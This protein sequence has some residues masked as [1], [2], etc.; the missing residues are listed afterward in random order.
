[1]NAM[2]KDYL[3][4]IGGLGS[5]VEQGALLLAAVFLLG[6][7]ALI[8]ATWMMRREKTS[9]REGRSVGLRD[10]D[11]YYFIVYEYR[12]DDGQLL[13]A[14]SE[15]S[16]RSLA[17][18][19]PGLMAQIHVPE[20]RPDIAAASPR[21]VAPAAGVLLA[22]SGLFAGF[23]ALT[24][25]PVNG[26]T[27]ATGIVLVVFFFKKFGRRMPT[28]AMREAFVEW[29]ERNRNALVSLP[30][31]LP[32]SLTETTPADAQDA[33]V[34]PA[35]EKALRVI[36]PLY[37]LAGAAAIAGALYFSGGMIDL[38]IA[39]TSTRGIVTEIVKDQG[40][41]VHVVHFRDKD[42]NAVRFENKSRFDLPS[43]EEGDEV[44]VLYME[45]DPAGTAA[46]DHGW[47]AWLAPGLLACFGIFTLLSGVAA[48]PRQRD[49][50]R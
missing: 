21:G 11:G 42:G 3:K 13:Q 40:D 39:G 2:E 49:E 14:T 5:P 33:S 27:L 48:M 19:Q 18:C 30:V 26:I 36:G 45:K 44:G 46:I 7:G 38:A 12:D 32:D 29:R 37:M 10:A 35:Q 43:H 9:T 8:L 41:R 1:M 23:K 24:V 6:F 15:Q 34:T 25:Y 50:V 16:T 47:H 4:M 22:V 31:Q 28:P 17:A 20:K